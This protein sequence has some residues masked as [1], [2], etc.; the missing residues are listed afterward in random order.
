MIQYGCGDNSGALILSK[1]TF[2]KREID[3]EKKILFVI[4]TNFLIIK[5]E[6]WMVKDLS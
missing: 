1:Q 6:T 2:L 3:L 4:F 5:G